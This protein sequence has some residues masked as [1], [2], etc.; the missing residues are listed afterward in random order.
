M[1]EDPAKIASRRRARNVANIA[2]IFALL[3][4]V[5]WPA[6]ST[7]A[8]IQ[9]N[10]VILGA[11]FVA[12]L[13]G[14][15]CWIAGAKEGRRTL[16]FGLLSPLVNFAASVAF[17]MDGFTR[18]RA[19]RRG[20]KA[21]I[22]ALRAGEGWTSTVS[23]ASQPSNAAADA[24][25]AYG[26][27]EH[28][29]IAAFASF[30]NQLL[31]LGAPRYLVE[32]AFADGL[33]EVR[34]ADLCF[35]LAA[36]LDGERREPAPFPAAMT[37]PESK[38]LLEIAKECLRES[39]VLEMGS[40]FLAE[41]MLEEELVPEVRRVLEEI[42]RDER[43]H[44]EHGYEA[45]AWMRSRLSDTQRTSLLSV[46]DEIDPASLRGVVEGDELKH[47][48]VGSQRAWQLAVSDALEEAKNRLDVAGSGRALRKNA[49]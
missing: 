37:A 2:L 48:G 43:R 49:A 28:A 33:D 24:W 27:T 45:L 42:A 29:S 7:N 25:R 26:Q 14:L 40:A 39:C 17:V 6:C 47:F 4:L 44:A 38:E 36:S 3:P 46:L 22:A 11:S 1:V 20:G 32:Y 13:V 21:K 34:H 31:A 12:A 16:F 5:S 15:F 10:M 18:G 30:A 19:L 35:S 41:R 9:A 23:R 8:G